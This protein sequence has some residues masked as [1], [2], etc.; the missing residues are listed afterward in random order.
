M[1]RLSK[2][3]GQYACGFLDN[4]LEL[5]ISILREGYRLVRATTASSSL[6][7]RQ[8][9][10]EATSPRHAYDNILR[11][12]RKGYAGRRARMAFEEGNRGEF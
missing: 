11:W 9:R 5:R 1:H 3:Y 4:L 6:P 8:R 7:I 12:I 2:I 10:E